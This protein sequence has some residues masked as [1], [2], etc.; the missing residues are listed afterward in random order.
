[1]SFPLVSVGL[2]T[3]NRADLLSRAL[4]SLVAQTYKNLEIVISDNSSSDQT[5]EVC[6]MYSSRYSWIRFRRQPTRVPPML[7]FRTALEL[8]SGRYFMWASDDD[9]WDSRFVEKL[10][11]GLE[12]DSS[13]AL[14]SAEAR[15]RLDD[16]TLLDFFPEGEFWYD[17]PPQTSFQ[18]AL[19]VLRHNF[20][21]L[22]YGIYRREALMTPSGTVL[23]RMNYVNEIPLFLHIAEKGGIRVLPEVLFFKTT[24]MRTYLAAAREYR[25]RPDLVS[26]KGSH[27]KMKL[28]SELYRTTRYHV[29]T[30]LDVARAI[31]K[32]QFPLIQKLRLLSV[33]AV[34]LLTHYVK[35]GFIWPVEDSLKGS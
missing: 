33:A 34:A 4:E 14:L 12:S 24:N 35:V 28:G 21:N 10:V 16:D 3:F 13:L 22:I 1:M 20:G 5:P 26:R 31:S 11:A 25:F 19:S 17:P 9:L 15:Y 2:P 27:S 18:R 23:D 29:A 7:N 32:T 6:E 8:T 30:L